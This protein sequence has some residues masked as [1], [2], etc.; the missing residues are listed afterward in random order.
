MSERGAC[1]VLITYG[2]AILVQ[3]GALQSV[4][5]SSPF[6]SDAQK[7]APTEVH[8]AAAA[9]AAAA[10]ARKGIGGV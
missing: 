1:G 2:R 8:H 5:E 7:A 9:A 4:Q 6:F 3:A 10:A